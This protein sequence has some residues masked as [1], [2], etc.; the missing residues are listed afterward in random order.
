M[1]RW[2]IRRRQR[3]A[4][5]RQKRPSQR[6]SLLCPC[7]RRLRMPCSVLQKVSG[8]PCSN[9]S[10]SGVPRLE[11]TCSTVVPWFLMSINLSLVLP[12]NFPWSIF[13]IQKTSSCSATQR[14]RYSDDPSTLPSNQVML[15]QQKSM[16]HQRL[17]P[18]PSHRPV[19]WRKHSARRTN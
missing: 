17:G 15:E 4:Q 9:V 14:R 10:Q 2:S 11:D 16:A 8:R 13:G 6:L 5:G 3:G 19:L 12:T 7:L 1:D 18:P